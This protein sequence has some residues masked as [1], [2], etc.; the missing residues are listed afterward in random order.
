MFNKIKTYILSH[1][2]V[3]GIIFIGLVIGIYF[4][5]KGNA[6]SETRYVTELVKIG[7][8]TTTVTGTGQVEASDTI[9][10]KPKVT[11]DI[12]FVGVKAG[13]EVKK[14]TLIASIDSRDAKIALQNA[15]ITLDKLVGD[16]DSL[17]LLQKQNNL[18]KSYSDGWNTVSSFVTDMN[19]ITDDV[20]EMYSND[21]FFGYQGVSGLNSVGRNKI[22]IAEDDYYKAKS[23]LGE[24]NKLYKTLS[25]SSSQEEVK[26]LINKAY[27]TSKIISNMM[28]DTETA[29][30]YQVDALESKDDTKTITAKSNVT[31]WLNS[32]NS[33]VSSLL[34]S[35]NSIDENNQSLSDLVAGAD[36]LDI[37]SAK[38][39]V[40]NKQDAYD[41]C[42]IRAPF[43]GVI[44]TL[45][46]KVGESSGSSVGT[47]MT[48]QKIATI[49]LNEVD[50]ASISLDQKANLTFDAIDGL[51]VEGVVS[52]I[53]SVGTVSSGVV[54][55]NVK[56]G[57]NEKDERIKPGMSVNV[58]IITA[59][60]Q[61]ILT[62]SSG[63]VKTKNG[64]SYVEIF[65]N[66]VGSSINPQGI[67]STISPVKKEV[68][69]G[70]SDDSLTEIIS[71]L[72]E[73]DQIITK[74]TTGT[75]SATVSASSSK[76]GTGSMSG[77]GGVPMGG[78][79]MGA[80]I[81]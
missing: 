44:A 28:K 62:V 69:V 47:L 6:N 42:F 50:I 2:V 14:G 66:S 38:L 40:Q 67:T 22:S 34:S 55:Y 10:L 21:G 4:L 3:F 39:T 27:D 57:F 45:T 41:D 68:E 81:H 52:E 77:L 32:A 16:P 71:G 26:N 8:I 15:Q 60:K 30:N 43:D 29:V 78:S 54:T 33:Y 9:D 75:S 61:N 74:T 73:G 53:D 18:K 64:K 65:E 59:S 19:A 31:S 13:Q 5:F 56:I 79:A 46:A 7:N 48:K 51:T 36:E 35:L 17:T 72:N 20:Y 25:S 80:I 11:G 70:I 49:S 12:T 76:S 37:R 23:S 58:E 63:A 1:R 24:L